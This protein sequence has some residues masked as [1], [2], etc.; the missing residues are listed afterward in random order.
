VWEQYKAI[1]VGAIAVVVAQAGMI[2]WLIRYARE[3]ARVRDE[4]RVLNA[5]LEERVEQRTA[6]LGQARDRAEVLLAEVN[7]RV[8][9]SL[10]LVASLVTLQTNVV[11]EQAAKDALAATQARIYAILSVNKQLYASGDVRSVTMDEYFSGLLDRDIDAEPGGRRPTRLFAT[12]PTTV[13]C[14]VADAGVTWL[15]SECHAAGGLVAKMMLYPFPNTNAF[16]VRQIIF[17][18]STIVRIRRRYFHKDKCWKKFQVSPQAQN[19]RCRY[20]IG[21]KPKRRSLNTRTFAPRKL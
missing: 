15:R 8:G 6:D 16:D 13:P 5:S 11:T 18:K 12:S 21:S 7:H 1:I 10:S 20:R 17:S 14:R 19:G 4:V 3:I 2:A 9:N